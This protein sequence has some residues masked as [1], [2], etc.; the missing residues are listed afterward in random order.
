MGRYAT[1][2]EE[3][4]RLLRAERFVDLFAVVR[5]ALR[6]GV[7]SYSI[8]QLE[9]FYGFTREVALHDAGTHLQAIELALESGAPTAIPE[10]VRAA[11]QGYNRD[12]C[13]ST[14]ALRDWLETLRNKAMLDGADI[15]RPVPKDDEPAQE[16]GEREARQQAARDRSYRAVLSVTRRKGVAPKPLLPK[17]VSTKGALAWDLRRSASIW[18][19]CGSG[20]CGRPG[21]RRGGCWTRR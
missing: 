21:G 8:K 12:D 6:A 13:H 7:E 19:G 5:Q 18:D 4:D 20:M 11:V 9:Q 14:E 16:L 10:D 2:G 1:R 17:P 3:L 15:Q